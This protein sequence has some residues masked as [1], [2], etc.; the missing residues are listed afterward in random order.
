MA[1]GGITIRFDSAKAPRVDPL[2]GVTR[3]SLTRENA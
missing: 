2:P 3:L 1:S